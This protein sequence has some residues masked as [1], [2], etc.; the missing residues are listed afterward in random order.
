MRSRHAFSSIILFML[1][2]GCGGGGGGGFDLPPAAI[3]GQFRQNNQRTGAGIGISQS[4][5]VIVDM[6]FVD[7]ITAENPFPSAVSGSPAID[8][9]GRL[10]I[11]SEGGTLAGFDGNDDLNKIW[12]VNQCDVCPAGNQ[13]LGALVS[14]PAVYTYEDTNK[15]ERTSVFVGSMDSAVFLYQFE[16]NNLVNSGDCQVCFWRDNQPL[17]QAFVASDPGATVSAAFAS[18]PTFSANLGTGSIAGIFI[19][20]TITIEHT[21]GSTE[22]QGKLYAINQ[23]GSLRW[24]FPR[25]G[26]PPI[27]PVTSSP[28]FAVGQSIFFTTTADPNSPAAGDMLYSLTEAGNLKRIV[29][30]AGLTDPSLLLSPS[31][32]T[33]STVYVSAVNGAIHAMNPDGTFLWNATVQGER[34]TS[35]LVIGAQNL[36]TP[37]ASPAATP[38]PTG[39]RV[40]PSVTATP[41]TTETP[42]RLDSNVL[43]ITESGML[44]VLD[45]RKGEIIAPTGEQPPVAIEGTVVASPALSAD[46]FIIFGTTGG[47]LLSL[48]TANAQFPRFCDGGD[49]DGNLCTDDFDCLDGFCADSEW[50]IF[51][52][53]SCDAGEQQSQLCETDDDCPGGACVRPAIRSS[54]TLDLDG[55]IY[56]GADDGRIYAVDEEPTPGETSSPVAT[57]TPQASPTPTATQGVV[58]TVTP[59]H[60][61]TPSAEPTSTLA[62]TPTEEVS[63]T[64]TEAM[65]PS[66]SPTPEVND[67]PTMEPTPE[68]NDTPTVEPTAEPTTP[69]AP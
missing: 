11:G 39:T 19:G 56:F 23:D 67:T 32:M 5:G 60:E 36:P 12:S 34:F 10:Y 53:S 58:A 18:S 51:L 65:P 25:A 8:A 54:P 43:G 62:V 41:T 29:P 46:L 4:K 37:T 15:V 44:V 42:L 13:Q 66:P 16:H 47:Q 35:S 21:D 20:A 24:E 45:S 57:A 64:E 69:A 27:A 52:P 38:T 49:D 68:V 48:N 7:E 50:P 61:A 30:I 9:D 63:P 59:T 2:T 28:A 55:T 17:Q 31:P 3:W 14:S 33:A 40:D 26:D 1:A 22:K 6:E